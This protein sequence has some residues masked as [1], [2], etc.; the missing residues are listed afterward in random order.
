[1]KVCII[2]HE[3]PPTSLGGGQGTYAMNLVRELTSNGHKVTVITP[4]FGGGKAYE[5][6]GGLE[7]RRL[8]LLQPPNFLKFII[9][10]VFDIRVMLGLKLRGFEGVDFGDYD[11]I[12]ILDVHDSY[13]IGRKIKPPVVVSVNDYYSFEMPWNIFRFPYFCA[14]LPLRYLH[15]AFTKV[16]NS[17]YLRRADRIISD[18]RYTAETIHRVAKV[19]KSRIEVIYKGIDIDRFAGVAEPGKYTSRRILYI[20]GNMERKGV[21]YLVRAMA[22]IT[23]E[24]PDA[25]LTIIG[26]ASKIYGKKLRAIIKKNGL[27]KYIEHLPYC[28]PEK[29]GEYYKKA[30]VFVL[31][32]I[33]E[34]LGQVL[35]ESM[36]TRTPVVSTNVGAN[37]EAIVDGFNGLLVDAKTPRQIAD[38]VARIFSDPKMAEEMGKNGRAMAERVFNSSRML[39]ETLDVYNKVIKY[40]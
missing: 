9:M 19:P 33:I 7:I 35:I 18:T 6:R 31:P 22:Y 28:P 11:I 5:K 39:R 15:H 26:R 17:F 40:S 30:N 29:I 34:D 25:R 2:T 32:S 24:F 38:A 20:G 36:S 3:Y 10:N 16:F 13:F 4:I 23:R 21:E 37:P 14:D 12:H 8:K 27:R 1:M